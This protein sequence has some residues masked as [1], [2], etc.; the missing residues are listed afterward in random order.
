MIYFKINTNL[1]FYRFNPPKDRENILKSQ[2]RQD[3]LDKLIKLRLQENK[4]QH[5][6]SFAL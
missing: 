1:L 3:I 2:W 6:T 4:F 5:L